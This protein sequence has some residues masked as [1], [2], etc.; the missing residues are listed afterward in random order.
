MVGVGADGGVRELG[1]LG[2]LGKI[3][4]LGELGSWGGFLKLVSCLVIVE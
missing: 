1:A 2:R 3:G 4:E